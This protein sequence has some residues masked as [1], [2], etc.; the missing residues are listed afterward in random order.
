MRE[1]KSSDEGPIVCFTRRS[2]LIE[3][4]RSSVLG[5]LCALIAERGPFS[6]LLKHVM[7]CNR[8]LLIKTTAKSRAILCQSAISASEGSV[9]TSPPLNRKL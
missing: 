2:H 5:I 6:V 9:L 7:P 1:K 4:K 8:A 3:G